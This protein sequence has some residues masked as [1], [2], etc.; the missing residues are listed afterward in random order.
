[1]VFRAA[2]TLQGPDGVVAT[3]NIRVMKPKIFSMWPIT[4]KF[5]SPIIQVP[6]CSL[7][8]Q[9]CNWYC[10]LHVFS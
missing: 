6:I 5:L 7:V 2:F 10:F 3:K 8:P 1:M 4:E 9:I